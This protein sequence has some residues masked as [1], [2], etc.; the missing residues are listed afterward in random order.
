MS[1]KEDLEERQ[2]RTDF[3]LAHFR[4]NNMQTQES[5]TVIFANHLLLIESL[6]N[7]KAIMEYLLDEKK[8]GYEYA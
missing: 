3:V 7:Q 6:E 8:G 4:L 5:G 1:A 2:R